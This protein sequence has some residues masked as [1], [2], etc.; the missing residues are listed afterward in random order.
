[1]KLGLAAGQQKNL[2]RAFLALDDGWPVDLSL[3]AVGGGV[4]SGL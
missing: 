3:M 2:Q 1:M 4:D